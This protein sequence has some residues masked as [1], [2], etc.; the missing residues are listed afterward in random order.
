MPQPFSSCPEERS[1]EV[2]KIRSIDISSK[3]GFGAKHTW[4]QVQAVSPTLCVTLGKL[5]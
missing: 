2:R 4:L 1:D 3:R 5:T